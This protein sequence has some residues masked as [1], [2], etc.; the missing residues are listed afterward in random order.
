MRG[1]RAGGLDM[2]ARWEALLV[3]LLAATLTWGTAR[4]E[5]FLEG[6]NF[7]VA[8]STF[9]ERAI[10]A[11]PMTL[12]IISGEIDLSVASILGLASAILGITWEAGWPLGLCI[13]AALAT[14]AVAGLLN[15]LL[16]TRL[17]LPSLVVTLG[18]LALY[19]GLAYVVLGG[20]GG[21][22]AISNFPS[23]FVDFGFRTI[24]G[25]VVPW[26]ALV[27]LGLL[28][29]ALVVLHRTWVGRQIYAM[30]LNKEAARYSTV[31][32]GALKVWL[33]VASGTVAALAGV[34][35]TARIS[36]SRA[37]N[38]LGFEL[39]VI[40]AVLLGG[41]SIFGGRGNLIGVALS[42]VVVAALRNV[43]A[44]TNVGPDV[45]S[46]AVGGLLILSVLGP[47]LVRR[48]PRGGP[49]PSSGTR[50]FRPGSEPSAEPQPSD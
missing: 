23:R 2:L 42:L 41:V 32:V 26:S 17:G 48:L 46:L 9:M 43:L 13:A 8:S 44:I 6:S 36:S 49:R 10:M 45:Q 4:S 14:G 50:G 39:D 28:A 34:I 27:F 38:A 47:N 31:R 11:L 19:R 18:T 12:I 21:Q 1:A 7:A 25:T 22:K 30:G 29:V 16:V 24:P 37:D 40:A 5:F 20:Q 15:G 35:F 33:Y 3:A